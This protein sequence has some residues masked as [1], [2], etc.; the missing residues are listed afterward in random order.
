MIFI[1]VTYRVCDFCKMHG[2][3]SKLKLYCS[4]YGKQHFYV[5]YVFQLSY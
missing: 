1:K 2:K 4:L 3:W 5:I